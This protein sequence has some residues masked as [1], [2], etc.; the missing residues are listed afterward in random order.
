[1]VSNLSPKEKAL[2]LFS[3]FYNKIEDATAGLFEEDV[4]YIEARNIAAKNCSISAIEFAKENPLNSE[5][6][7][8]YLELIKTELLNETH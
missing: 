8:K 6:Y 1:M 4:N 5:G 2:E 3:I 7:N